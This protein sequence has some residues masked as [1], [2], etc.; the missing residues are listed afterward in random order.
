MAERVGPVHGT[1]RSGGYYS[2]VTRGAKDA[3]DSAVPLV[4]AAIR[5]LPDAD[6]SRP[7]TLA[8]IGC[9]DGGTSLDLVHQAILGVRARWSRRPLLVVY[10]DQPRNDYNSLF[11]LIHGL[12]PT[13]SYLDTVDDVY[14]LATATSFYRPLMPPGTLDL[15]FSAAAMHWLSRKPVDLPAHIQAVGAS[16]R[17]LAAFAEQAR[18]DWETLLLQRA[19]A[20]TGRPAGAGQLL[21]GRGGPLHGPHRRPQHVRGPQHAVAALRR[22]GRDSPR[23]VCADDPV[24]LLPDRRGVHWAADRHR[25]SGLPHGPAPGAVRDARHSVPLCSG[26][27]PPRRCRALRLRV[28]PVTTVM[29]REHV[30]GRACARS[31]A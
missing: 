20:R 17:D 16:G 18:Q 15:G 23:R 2:A 22:R 28:Y 24:R 9:A 11:Q 7:F 3:I 6:A 14:V 4:L 29:E 30:S 19:R 12:T 21:S 8:D 31:T 27:P 10:T 13:P 25:Q 26:L 1:M 5:C